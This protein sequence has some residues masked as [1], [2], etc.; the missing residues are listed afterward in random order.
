MKT[1]HRVKKDNACS[2]HIAILDYETGKVDILETKLRNDY[3]EGDVIH[4]LNNMGYKENNI[5]YMYQDTHIEI[6]KRKV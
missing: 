1:E 4:F 2:V 3:E 6:R 5:E